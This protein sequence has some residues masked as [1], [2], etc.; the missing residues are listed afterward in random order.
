[1]TS[2]DDRTFDHLVQ[3]RSSLAQDVGVGGVEQPVVALFKQ[4][5]LRHA[6]RNFRGEVSF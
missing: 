4:S 3:L 2:I 1:M 5:L 6:A